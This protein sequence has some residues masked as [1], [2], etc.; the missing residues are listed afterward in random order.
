MFRK[1]GLESEASPT[2]PEEGLPEQTSDESTAVVDTV[3]E[4]DEDS[5]FDKGQAIVEEGTIITEAGEDISK[6]LVTL[7]T[8][9]TIL[10]EAP[11]EEINQT[12]AA[13]V[14]AAIQD[15]NDRFETEP[16]KE[17]S[18]EYFQVLGN[19]GY[20]KTANEAIGE[21]VE[22][23]KKAFD[24]VV[25]KIIGWVKQF[26]NWLFQNHKNTKKKLDAAVKTLKGVKGDAKITLAG[27]QADRL[28][29]DDLTVNTIVN[30]GKTLYNVCHSVTMYIN[31]GFDY[32]L[33][34]NGVAF[35]KSKEGSELVKR[36]FANHKQEKDNI[37]VYEGIGGR[38]VIINFSEHSE[39]SS[40]AVVT[41]KAENTRSNTDLELDNSDV[42]K[43]VTQAEET[44]KASTDGFNASEKMIN[45]ITAM[46]RHPEMVARGF[47]NKNA[48]LFSNYGKA[49]TQLS[50]VSYTESLRFTAAC[51]AVIEQY[52]K[53]ITN[54]DT[55]KVKETPDGKSDYIDVDES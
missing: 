2:I 35:V 16:S 3:E 31:N 20:R 49:I 27:Y 6:A 36:C 38:N 40:F 53:H 23:F 45:K 4:N 37:V 1:L 24:T 44:L 30:N 50:G 47:V 42:S 19:A 41:E 54:T 7:E 18:I 26:W 5:E 22:Q 29:S 33:F 52:V 25:D 55:S 9:S 15:I 28:S 10:A 39:A 43:I 51:T 48:Q 11:E 34:G 8:I 13:I 32:Q 21:R 46:R 17:V 14:S 12:T